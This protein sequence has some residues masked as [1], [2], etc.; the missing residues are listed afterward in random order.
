MSSY[1]PSGSSTEVVDYEY[2]AILKDYQQLKTEHFRHGGTY[3]NP[4]NSILL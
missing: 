3:L 2:S 1:S 4:L